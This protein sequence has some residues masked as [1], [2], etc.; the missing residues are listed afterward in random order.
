[1]NIIHRHRKIHTALLLSLLALTATTESLAGPRDFA[2][3]SQQKNDVRVQRLGYDAR[4]RAQ[5][6][7]VSYDSNDNTAHANTG[8]QYTFDAA[9][10]LIKSVSADQPPIIVE[11]F[12][13]GLGQLVRSKTNGIV[14]DYV[15]DESGDLPRIIGEIKGSTETL[16]V[17]G[18]EGLHATRT[19][20]GT[21]QRTD[22][23][24]NDGLGSVKGI[25]DAS[26]AVVST[27]AYDSWGN[28]RYQNGPSTALGYTGEQTF[29]DGTVYLRARSYLPSQ[30]RFL[31]RDSFA[32]F[33]GN[34][35]SQNRYAYAEGNPV[36]RTDPSGHSPS[37][38]LGMGQDF[39]LS[40]TENIVKY[41]N[42][43]VRNNPT[44]AIYIPAS[45]EITVEGGLSPRWQAILPGLG[46]IIQTA[47]AG[48]TARPGTAPRITPP[49]PRSPSTGPK[50]RPQSPMQIAGR[51]AGSLS[52]TITKA[53]YS[54]GGRYNT[55][56]G[57]PMP[58]EPYVVMTSQN[59][60]KSWTHRKAFLVCREKTFVSENRGWS[61]YSPNYGR[62]DMNTGPD[63]IKPEDLPFMVVPIR[64]GSEAALLDDWQRMS[65]AG[66]IINYSVP[67][68]LQALPGVGGVPG[69]LGGYNCYTQAL[70]C[71]N[72]A[73]EQY[74]RE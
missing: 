65:E 54:P 58:T 37:D 17:Y 72:A 10:R 49:R 28:T 48:R 39:S 11:Y 35:Q 73:V 63:K 21:T 62:S 57:D 66:K 29:A 50:P 18:P 41:L 5:H 36:S 70:N 8:T 47:A 46:Q 15:L 24:L 23:A 43:P 61:E 74:R 30:G 52:R 40:A 19:I 60:L 1:M 32:G 69:P 31:Q 51:A 34:G 45:G 7:G 38:E 55:Q 2:K 53:R 14:S 25:A 20:D 64:K 9:N 26:G 22:Y 27:R 12:Y 68:N 67:G 42:E 59:N 56:P 71:F 16:H 44:G 3:P 33:G 6:A 4:D 13:D